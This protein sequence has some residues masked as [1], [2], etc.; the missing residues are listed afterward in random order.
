MIGKVNGFGFGLYLFEE[1]FSFLFLK[2]FFKLRF[3]PRR[4]PRDFIESWSVSY[5]DKAI[6]IYFGVKETSRNNYSSRVK[7]LWM[8]WDWGPCVRRQIVNNDG[9]LV[10]EISDYQ[11]PYRDN[12]KIHTAPYTYTRNNGDIQNRIATFTEGE[13]EWRWRIT[14]KLPFRI[15][16]K[17]VS[18]SI[19]VSFDNEIGEKTGSWKG[20]C[21]GCG[22]EMLSFEKPLDTLR[23]MEAERK[24]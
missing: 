4:E 19:W 23:R 21:T 17:K 9:V 20:G 5:S 22:Y 10:D 3:L 15:G 24:F 8:P 6:F 2:W 13:M 7:I 11:P 12:R 16:P 14:H 1:G 18:R